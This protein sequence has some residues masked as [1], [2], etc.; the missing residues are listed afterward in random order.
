MQFG[1]FISW[2]QVSGVD[3]VYCWYKRGKI[4]TGA[5]I[6]RVRFKCRASMLYAIDIDTRKKT[7]MTLGHLFLEFS[8]S[9]RHGYSLLLIWERKSHDFGTFIS[10]VQLKCRSL[11][12]TLERKNHSNKIKLGKWEN[13][14][15]WLQD[16]LND[17]TFR[18]L[19]VRGKRGLGRRRITW[20]RNVGKWIVLDVQAVLTIAQK[21]QRRIC[22]AIINSCS[23]S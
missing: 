18:I 1:T 19:I 20:L 11:L 15:T 6:S 13:A 2:V 3:T 8:S 7:I 16:Q 12:L 23:C 9:I 17:E 22:F 4:M 5:I 10:R 21:G 14:V